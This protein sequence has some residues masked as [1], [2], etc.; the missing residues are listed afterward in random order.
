[1][2]KDEFLKCV[3][4]ALVFL[5]LSLVSFRFVPQD[6]HLAGQCVPDE[7]HVFQCDVH[8]AL[9]FR[10]LPQ[11]GQVDIVQLELYL[12]GAGDSLGH[13]HLVLVDLPLDEGL[14]FLVLL[15]EFPELVFELPL[16][17]LKLVLLP[18]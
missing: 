15:G 10:D 8:S 14:L 5:V 2:A 11:G 13:G 16:D 6:V 1:M 17:L 7:L 9:F 18:L 3:Q 4:E 12:G